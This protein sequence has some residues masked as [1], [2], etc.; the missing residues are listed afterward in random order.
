MSLTGEYIKKGLTNI[1][2]LQP[3]LNKLIKE[4]NRLRET[5]LI[6]YA[7]PTDKPIPGASILREDYYLI[8]DFLNDKSGQN[9]DVYLETPGGRGDV[10][11]DIVKCFRSRF[12]TVSFIIAGEAKSAG[13]I[14]AL[15]GDEIYMT[16]TGSLGPI[17]AQVRLGRH[18]ISTSDYLEWVE[19]KRKE[20]E[21][22]GKLNPFDATMIAQ[23]S[24]GE[25]NG[26]LH[27]NRFAQDRVAEWLPQYKFKKWGKTEDRKTTVT[28]NM[29]KERAK[30]I[31]KE[32]A[33]NSERWRIHGR[34]IKI[35]DLTDILKINRVEDD[36]KISNIIQRIHTVC[37]FLF[38]HGN[39]FKV[40][41]TVNDALHL[42][43]QQ[44][45]PQA[46]PQPIPQPLD[47]VLADIT[48]NKCKTKHSFYEKIKNIPEIDIKMKNQGR[49]PFPSGTKFACKCNNKIGLTKIK[50][51]IKKRIKQST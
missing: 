47:V 50:K 27:A 25:L 4:Y 3:E 35:N 23:V 38:S 43:A 14:L 16:E 12:E 28:E 40:V 51:D 1:Q 41:A 48:C 49:K 6:V 30:E 13:T 45:G 37:R 20:A 22:T 46:P 7:S 11:E 2:Q 9:L 5:Y 10:V 18:Q 33:A 32:L 29:K 39:C 19:N 34:S 26:V 42:I 36:P 8:H 24:P 31:A 44:A 21:K 17:D 15:S